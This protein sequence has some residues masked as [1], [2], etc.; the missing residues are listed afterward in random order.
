MASRGNNEDSI[1]GGIFLFFVVWYWLKISASWEE[2]ECRAPILPARVAQY[3]EL[4][5]VIPL[6][7]TC[8]L[9]SILDKIFL[10]I[11]Y[12]VLVHTQHGNTE[13]ESPTTSSV[14]LKFDLIYIPTLENRTEI[15]DSSD[16]YLLPMHEFRIPYRA[17]LDGAQR[18]DSVVRSTSDVV[19][20]T[21]F[22][23]DS[24]NLFQTVSIQLS[25]L[26][27]AFL[28]F[29]R[30]NKIKILDHTCAVF[31]MLTGNQNGVPV[32]RRIHLDPEQNSS[33]RAE[34]HKRSIAQMKVGNR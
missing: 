12:G 15:E 10:S 11:S 8:K 5:I 21:L 26:W 17:L 30:T 9:L 24:L 6:K 25:F 32:Q 20:Y 13:D 22:K 28:K 33:S 4:G 3:D 7:L 23:E 27:N 29:L 18:F 14:I 19:R 31:G 2:D 1:S 16:I 34:L